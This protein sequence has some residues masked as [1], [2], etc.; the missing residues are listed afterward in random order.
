MKDSFDG[1]WYKNLIHKTNVASNIEKII[2]KKGTFQYSFLI[3]VIKH[4]FNTMKN[5]YLK[6]TVD[7]FPNDKI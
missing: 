1:K 6:L 4:D 3:Q 2:L 5:V 7:I